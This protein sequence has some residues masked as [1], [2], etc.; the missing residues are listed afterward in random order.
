VPAVAMSKHDDPIV[1]ASTA[2][3]RARLRTEPGPAGTPSGSACAITHDALS[4]DPGVGQAIVPNAACLAACGADA[5]VRAGPPGP[6]SRQ[7]QA[8]DSASEERVQGDPGPKG[9]PPGG[10]PHAFCA[11]SLLHRKISGIGQ[12]C[13]QPPFRRRDC[14]PHNCCQL[15]IAVNSYR[16]RGT[17]G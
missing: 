4:T 12:S 9:H 2:C 11:I 15:L 3:L 10:P 13:L 5:L 14:P 16:R 7:L 17:S 6:A 8:P 1:C